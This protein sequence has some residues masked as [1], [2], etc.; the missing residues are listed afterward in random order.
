MNI[1]TASGPVHLLK[2]L[3]CGDKEE[4]KYINEHLSRYNR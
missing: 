1:F 4:V 2:K 3:G